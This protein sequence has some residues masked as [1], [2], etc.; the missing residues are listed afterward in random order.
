MTIQYVACALHAGYLR[1]QTHIQNMQCFLLFHGHV[2]YANVPQCYVL[3]TFPIL[4]LPSMGLL[5]SSLFLSASCSHRFEAFH[6]SFYMN[7]LLSF[8]SVKRTDAQHILVNLCWLTLT[9]QLESI[10]SIL[11]IYYMW[12]QPITSFWLIYI[13]IYI[14][15]VLFMICIVPHAS[16]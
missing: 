5:C 15:V 9:Y 8:C 7:L 13:Y 16:T 12:Y 3:R 14:Y 6:V 4:P 1:L 11:R 2:G 10:S